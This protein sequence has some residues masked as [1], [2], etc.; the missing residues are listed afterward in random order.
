[1]VFTLGPLGVALGGIIIYG[2]ALGILKLFKV[3]E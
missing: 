3:G 2:I 1:M